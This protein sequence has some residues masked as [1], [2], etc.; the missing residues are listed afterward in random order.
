[1]DEWVRDLWDG[2][3]DAVLAYAVRRTDRATAEEVVADTFA[4][5]WRR[6]RDV[7][8]EPLLW[9]LRVASN[10]L[11]TRKRGVAR[12]LRRMNAVLDRS[13]V[14]GGSS[15]VGAETAASVRVHQA[16]AALRPTDRRALMLTAW[17]GLSPAEAA[18]VMG[19]TRG[20]MDVRLHRARRRFKEAFDAEGA[21]DWEG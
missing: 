20:A 8:E 7:P 18:E 15:G 13:H 14:G 17:D 9:L 4:V 3:A 6:A 19:C 12:H 10:V 1:M 5:A 21:T 11:R 2:Y 16:L